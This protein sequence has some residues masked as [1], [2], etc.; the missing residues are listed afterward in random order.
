[1]KHSTF[2]LA[3]LL[4][5]SLLMA[6]CSTPKVRRPYPEATYKTLPPDPDK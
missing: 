5:D 6:A 3:I 1:M 2:W 4:I